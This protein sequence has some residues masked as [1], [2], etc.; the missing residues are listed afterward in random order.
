MY[1][2][3]FAVIQNYLVKSMMAGGGRLSKS[4]FREF[5]MKKFL[6]GLAC[7][8]VA[9]SAQAN[10]KFIGDMVELGV[11]T[12]S[13]LL[14]KLKKYKCQA[15][16]TYNG[17]GEKML[18]IPGKCVDG[19]PYMY[20]V[21]VAFA[22]PG[23]AKRVS[24]M[25]EPSREAYEYWVSRAKLGYGRPDWQQSNMTVWFSDN[26]TVTVSGGGRQYDLYYI[27]FDWKGT[28]ASTRKPY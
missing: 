21:S 7:L 2:F 26:L 11:T 6:V 12:E 15:R 25:L 27:G 8:T 5:D 1:H 19:V 24:F 9:F 23:E 16:A 18:V 3:D 14:K 13:A 22:R 28:Y 4:I 10:P 20:E 17:N